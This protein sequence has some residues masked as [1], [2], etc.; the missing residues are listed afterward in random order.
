[1]N[2]HLKNELENA[3]NK[4]A[5][6][7]DI[8]KLSAEYQKRIDGFNEEYKRI[9]GYPARKWFQSGVVLLISLAVVGLLAEVIP[10]SPDSNAGNFLLL[11]I[12]VSIILNLIR[13]VITEKSKKQ[14]A[15]IWWEKTAQPQVAALQN[16]IKR[17][18]K[19][20][21]VIISDN[22]ILSAIPS[23]MRSC[24][25]VYELLMIVERGKAFTL[26]AALD[27]W[28]NEQENR[29][30]REDIREGLEKIKT[31]QRQLQDELSKANQQLND[32]SFIEEMHYWQHIK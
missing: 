26:S 12:P 1:M 9:K 18:N 3:L 23:G 6:V 27:V 20:I 11:I 8:L 14:K 22:S 16:E 17:H 31:N 24:N 15:D 7:E 29:S 30:Y 25:T 19:A 28:F 32:I 13:I 10:V 4:M 21:Y 5:D 2:E